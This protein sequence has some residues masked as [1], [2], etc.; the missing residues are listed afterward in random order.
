[1]IHATKA[2]GTALR[3]T[4]TPMKTWSMAISRAPTTKPATSVRRVH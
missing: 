3:P 4:M 1:M 2:S